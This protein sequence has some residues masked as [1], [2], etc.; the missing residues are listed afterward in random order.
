M[1]YLAKSFGGFKERDFTSLTGTS[2]RKDLSECIEIE[3]KNL[4]GEKFDLRIPSLKLNCKN[5]IGG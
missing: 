1:V 4:T 3:L 5:N 2:W